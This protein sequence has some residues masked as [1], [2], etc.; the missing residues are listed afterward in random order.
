MGESQSDG[1][2]NF[3]PPGLLLHHDLW[4]QIMAML[5]K[6]KA[7]GLQAPVLSASDFFPHQGPS[8]VI[9]AQLFFQFHP[10]TETI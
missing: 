8:S 6:D 7:S 9:N 4:T 2:I 5:D 3:W 10:G 1:S